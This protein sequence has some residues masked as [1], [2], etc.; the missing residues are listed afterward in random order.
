MIKL[1]LMPYCDDC[2]YFEADEV[3]FIRGR[4]T[5][6]D[7]EGNP[8]LDAKG[9]PTAAPFPCAGVVWRSKGGKMA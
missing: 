9:K 5:F 8:A 6:T 1:A 3:R 4:L 2:P 7:E